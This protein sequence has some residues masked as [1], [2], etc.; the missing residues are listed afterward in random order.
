MGSGALVGEGGVAQQVAAQ[1]T[2]EADRDPGGWAVRTY[3]D[4]ERPD[5]LL[6]ARD[7]DDLVVEARG[8]RADGRLD[9]DHQARPEHW[10]ASEAAGAVGGLHAAWE[11]AELLGSVERDGSVGGAGVDEHE[12]RDQ[13]WYGFAP[14]LVELLEMERDRPGAGHERAGHLEERGGRVAQIDEGGTRRLL[15]GAVPGGPPLTCQTG[16]RRP[17]RATPAVG[18]ASRPPR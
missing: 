5:A 11:K 2:D 1:Q 6:E 16:L 12:S 14:A 10:V 4:A 15:R 17:T 9:L 18:R 7:G 13:L 3:L 8:R